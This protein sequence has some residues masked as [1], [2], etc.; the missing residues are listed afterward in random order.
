MRQGDDLGALG[1]AQGFAIGGLQVLLGR[2]AAHLR[3]PGQQG[4]L[5]AQRIDR[6]Q[7]PAKSC[8]AGGRIATGFGVPPHP[9]GGQ[10]R[11]GETP[12]K[13]LQIPMAARR[14]AKVSAAHHRQQ[15]A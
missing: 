15:A 3:L 5:D 13:G 14:P 2:R 9:Q 8:F 10:L 1:V 12:G 6:A 4:L 7:H 11:L